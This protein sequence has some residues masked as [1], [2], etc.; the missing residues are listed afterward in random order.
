M[1]T[2]KF[3]PWSTRRVPLNVRTL[4]HAFSLPYPL[5]G[6][7]TVCIMDAQYEEGNLGGIAYTLD[8]GTLPYGWAKDVEWSETVLT[9]SKASVARSRGKHGGGVISVKPGASVSKE[10]KKHPQG[11]LRGKDQS[12][13][14]D[15]YLAQKTGERYVVVQ[16]AR[17]KLR[18]FETLLTLPQSTPHRSSLN[19]RQHTNCTLRHSAGCKQP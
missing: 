6:T 12:L 5:S 9:I 16:G 1:T 17:N 15:R 3:R 7:T 13:F 2:C 4:I 8:E 10:K 11:N 18:H 14:G 19:L